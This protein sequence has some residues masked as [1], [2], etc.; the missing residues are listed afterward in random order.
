MAS[1]SSSGNGRRL[2]QFVDKDGIRKTVRLGKISKKQAESFRVMVESLVTASVLGEPEALDNATAQWLAGLDDRLYARVAAVGLVKPRA[3]TLGMGIAAFVESFL[4]ARP[5]YKPLTID[6]VNQA[7][8]YLIEHFGNR[9]MRTI[10]AA[11]AEDFRLSLVKSGLA[12]ATYRRHLGRCRQL[13]KAAIK[14]GIVKGQNPFD[15]MAVTARANKERQ[16]FVSRADVDKLIAAAPDAQWRLII[17]LSRYGGIRTPSETL[18][19]KWTDVNW[20]QRR[21]RIPSPKTERYEGG[22]CRYIPLFPELDRPLHDCFE[23]A[24]PG[25]EY[26][27]NRHRSMSRN[28]G[29]QLRRIALRAGLEP[30]PKPFHNMRASRQTE[31]AESFPI[32]VVCSWIG[33]SRAVAQEHYLT[34]TDAHFARAIQPLAESAAK[35]AAAGGGIGENGGDTESANPSELLAIQGNSLTCTDGHNYDPAFLR[36]RSSQPVSTRA[37]RKS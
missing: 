29:T 14:R 37:C 26:V 7:R 13:F 18:A 3:A 25:E 6:N 11:D 36:V 21:L 9:D 16:R 2:I 33:N 35:S 24:E 34:V 12:E 1:I 27:I 31:L 17:A 28:L 30:W 23:L 4:A 22:D 32:H 5:E 10:T 15:D 8:H 20:E 19:L